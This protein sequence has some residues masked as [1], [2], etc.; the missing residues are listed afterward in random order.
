[1]TYEYKCKN[2][3]A[4]FET[5]MNINLVHLGMMTTCTKCECTAEHERYYSEA[6]AVI[7]KGGAPT[8]KGG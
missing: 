3:G 4:V 1:M 7:W 5:D 2:C 8:K 6:P